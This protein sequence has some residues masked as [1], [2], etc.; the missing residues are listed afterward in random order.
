MSLALV[1]QALDALHALVLTLALVSARLLGVMAIAPAFERLGL[2]NTMRGAAAMAFAAPMVA[3]AP[4]PMLDGSLPTMFAG[5]GLA[6]KEATVGFI[7]GFIFG[8][9]FWAAQAAG[10]IMDLQRGSTSATLIDPSSGTD[11]GVTG[12]LLTLAMLAMFFSANGVDVM[13]AAVYDSYLLWPLDR[14]WPQF[15]VAHAFIVLRLL[16][17]VTF[18]GVLM[19]APIMAA[20]LITDVVLA[21]VARAAPQLNAFSLSLALK[22][23]VFMLLLV[24]YCT[25]LVTYMRDGLAYGLNSAQVLG[26][27]APRR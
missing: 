1:S 22:N 25:F 4:P 21:F 2:T 3:V 9:P 6:L 12:T 26:E 27:L 23:L 5:V 10:D 19:A 13:V 24:V 11:A 20:M 7:I 17:D 14:L 8:I 16:N 18:L 15:E